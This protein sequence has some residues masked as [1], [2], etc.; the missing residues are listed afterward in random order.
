MSESVLA[1]A[2]R[3]VNLDR[4]EQYGHPY[5]NFEDTAR[6]WEVILGCSITPEQVGLCM[7]G[8]KLAREAFAPKRDN[9]VDLAGYA[10]T[11]DLVREERAL[12]EEQAEEAPVKESPLQKAIR[13]HGYIGPEPMEEEAIESGCWDAP[14]EHAAAAEAAAVDRRFV[15]G[16]SS[17]NQVVVRVDG[18]PI[19]DLDVEIPEWRRYFGERHGGR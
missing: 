3:I 17:P 16:Q 10:K 13:E 9:L 11:V 12:R 15:G 18:R 14:S 6:I 1:E 5:D 7:V 2:D 4:R 8:V 19:G